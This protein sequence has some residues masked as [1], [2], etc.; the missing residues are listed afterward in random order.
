MTK[1][2]GYWRTLSAPRISVS[3]RLDLVRQVVFWMLAGFR[4]EKI[5]RDLRDFRGRDY[6]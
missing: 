4:Q 3:G 5:L 6:A 1:Y 2:V